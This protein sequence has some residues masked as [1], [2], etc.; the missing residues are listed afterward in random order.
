M[1]KSIVVCTNYIGVNFDSNIFA[2]KLFIQIKI[3]N[4]YFTRNN[5]Y[6]L[7][8][9]VVLYTFFV[10]IYKLTVYLSVNICVG[11]LAVKVINYY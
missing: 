7:T 4:N 5:M 6:L 3:Y 2:T 11:L 8:I 10:Y 9:Y 1:R